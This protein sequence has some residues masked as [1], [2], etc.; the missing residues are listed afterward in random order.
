MKRIPIQQIGYTSEWFLAKFMQALKDPGIVEKFILTGIAGREK[1]EDD[2]RVRLLKIK[3]GCKSGSGYA[4]RNSAAMEDS[5]TTILELL[6]KGTLNY[7]NVNGSSHIRKLDRGETSLLYVSSTN[8]THINYLEDGATK[9]YQLLCEKPLVTLLD[10]MGMASRSELGRLEALVI[11]RGDTTMID[12]EHYSYKRAAKIFYSQLYDILK[13]SKIVSVKAELAEPDNPDKERN[14]SILSLKSQTGILTDTGVH[15]LSFVSSLGAQASPIP[16][17]VRYGVFPGYDV[18][19]S[20]EANYTL[21]PQ[22]NQARRCFDDSATMQISIEKFSENTK[23]E[24]KK[25]KRILFKLTDDSEVE[26]DLDKGTVIKKIDGKKIREYTTIDP[27]SNEYIPI[28]EETYR[29][30]TDKNFV[31]RTDFKNSIRTLNAVFQTYNCAPIKSN[32]S[33]PYQC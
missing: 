12:S 1:N 31:P 30:I 2:V 33:L 24:T 8:P 11:N 3:E 22:T 32:T 26:L 4:S 10:C 28:L 7:Y 25:S 29:A 9:G 21:S 23:R 16:E 17:T 18:E 27:S 19:T 15:L 5:A 13:D 14:K 20:V 6:E